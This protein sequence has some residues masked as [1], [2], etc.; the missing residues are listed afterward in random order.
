MQRDEPAL[1]LGVHV[2]TLLD[3]PLSHLQVVVPRSQV[4]GGGVAALLVLAVDVLLGDQL[5]HLAT[6]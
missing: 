6:E 2:G 1:V 4:E 3:Q 5:L